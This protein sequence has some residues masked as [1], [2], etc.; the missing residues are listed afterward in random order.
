MFG[1]FGALANA[2]PKPSKAGYRAGE[3]TDRC[4]AP[5]TGLDKDNVEA[6]IQ[7]LLSTR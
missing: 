7:A 4:S 6:N 1:H 2:H 3:C 5:A